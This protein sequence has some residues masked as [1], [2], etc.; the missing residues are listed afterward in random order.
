M[1]PRP[2]Y[3][4]ANDPAIHL[5]DEMA[6][7]TVHAG[8]SLQLE[9]EVWLLYVIGFVINSRVAFHW[10]LGRTVHGLLYRPTHYTV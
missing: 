8:G 1:G 2:A 10:L 3:P 4:Y 9:I 6:H 5:V 7:V